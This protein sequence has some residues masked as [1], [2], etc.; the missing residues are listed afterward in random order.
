MGQKFRKSNFV[1]KP[2]ENYDFLHF[3][4]PQKSKNHD[5]SMVFD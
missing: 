4:Q 3:S 2:I 5:F 1:Q